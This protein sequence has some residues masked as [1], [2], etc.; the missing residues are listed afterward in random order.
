MNCTQ[1]SKQDLHPGLVHGI[2]ILTS[3]SLTVGG[4]TIRDKSEISAGGRGMI[5][6]DEA[7]DSPHGKPSARLRWSK[8]FQRSTTG[9][10][11]KSTTS[12]W[13]HRSEHECR[14]RRQPSQAM[15]SLSS[16]SRGSARRPICHQWPLGFE[17]NLIF[18]GRPL[19]KTN[20]FHTFTSLEFL[21]LLAYAPWL[22]FHA[23]P[24]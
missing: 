4:T 7:K 15:P 9:S 6:I 22:S 2:T 14:E 5:T 11:T 24:I 10:I 19:R 3:G 13:R 8:A 1:R 23:L 18:P 12:I 21:S 17:S 20:F 16:R